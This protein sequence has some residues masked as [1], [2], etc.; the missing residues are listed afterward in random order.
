MNIQLQ[1]GYI[2]LALL[3][4]AVN[5]T[6]LQCD[7][8]ISNNFE[9]NDNS[10][11]DLFQNV[12]KY[13]NKSVNSEDVVSSEA[14]TIKNRVCLLTSV[15]D[16]ILSYAAYAIAINT[17]YATYRNYS[18]HIINMD[19]CVVNGDNVR[20]SIKD[21]RWH[22]IYLLMNALS[23]S[24][25]NPYADCEFVVWLDADLVVLD[26][27]FQFEELIREAE[28]A[29]QQSISNSAADSVDGILSIDLIMSRDVA[30]APFVSNSGC[31]VVR[32]SDWSRRLL[33]LW[34][35]SY[36]RER[37][38]DQNAFTWLYNRRIPADIQSHVAL[39]PTDRIN[40]DFPAWRNQR[41]SGQFLHLAGLNTLYR[42]RVFRQGLANVCGSS[43]RLPPQLGLDRAFLQQELSL[44][45]G[46]R[47]EA[48]ARIRRLTEL[49]DSCGRGECDNEQKAIAEALLQSVGCARAV[50][51]TAAVALCVRGALDDI[52]KYDDDEHRLDSDGLTESLFDQVQQ[53]ALQVRI[54]VFRQ[55]SDVA[56]GEHGEPLQVLEL[57]REAVSAGF[58]LVILLERDGGAT[59]HKLSAEPREEE[60]ESTTSGE[61]A[62][63]CPSMQLRRSLL[64]EI[65]QLL[66]TADGALTG[67]ESQAT[68]DS[69]SSVFAYYRF[70]HA[71]LSANTYFG[72]TATTVALNGDVALRISWLQRAA[73]AW[74]SM[75]STHNFY[76][77]QYVLADPQ[78][79]I[80][81]VHSELGLLHC[82][83]GRH[84]EG[85]AALA[86]SIDQQ[87]ATLAGYH[88]V[89]IATLDVIRLSELVLTETLVNAGICSFELS[90]S[91]QSADV[92]TLPKTHS[93]AEGSDRG[94]FLEALLL[95]D[96]HTQQPY[97]RHSGSYADLAV[98]VRRFL[99]L[100]ETVSTAD[101]STPRRTALIGSVGLPELRD[102]ETEL[103]ESADSSSIRP[104]GKTKQLKRRAH[105]P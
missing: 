31:I 70:K 78:R 43:R 79:E 54:W 27:D 59:S 40:S 50:E 81:A 80:A 47:L 18:I 99:N 35:S 51:S 95:I 92:V 83:Q 61:Q 13:A 74:S 53:K 76:G 89:Q 105:K 44:L 20:S 7:P 97:N 39:L 38:C 2:W 45:N 88:S 34:F 66:Q 63:I 96:A 85:L 68:V 69:F 23:P 57:V 84:A 48:L 77:T 11:G 71:Q 58:E 4:A 64:A 6:E 49:G 3:A 15:T 22:K 16:N 30:N 36:D 101:A 12:L 32:N 37:C 52:V 19:D 82:T 1:W 62:S 56:R 86:V 67:W 75:A 21:A 9:S 87:R 103:T 60:A 91:S 24:P 104:G 55:L 65:D 100:L 28:Q 93:A 5:G 98:T 46:L 33:G 42:V 8:F 41:S 102:S 90:A 94:Y 17:M 14:N 72:H 25:D 26:F 73:S 10:V 29:L